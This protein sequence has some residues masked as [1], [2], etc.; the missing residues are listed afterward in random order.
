MEKQNKELEELQNKYENKNLDINFNSV[1]RFI[2]ILKILFIGTVTPIVLLSVLVI[3]IAFIII[4]MYWAPSGYNESIIQHLEGIY[5]DN[6]KIISQDLN[7]NGDGY[8]RI[9]IKN[10]E[11]IIFNGYH[12]GN[13]TNYEDSQAYK[14]K[15]YFEHL[16]NPELKE[17]F[18][19]KESYYK[20]KE[21]SNVDFLK[22]ELTTHVSSYAEFENRISKCY[23]MLQY[24]K[25]KEIYG[26]VIFLIYNDYW[27]GFGQSEENLDYNSLLAKAKNDYITYLKNRGANTS[28]IPFNDIQNYYRPETLQ[29]FINEKQVEAN[30]QVGYNQ[31]IQ[32]YEILYFQRVVNNI[33]TIEKL[34]YDKGNA[35]QIKYNDKVYNLHYNNN[36][37][38]SNNIPCTCRISYLEELFNA[39]VRYDYENK[40]IYIDI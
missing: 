8:Y 34:K 38:K 30:G 28:E 5:P 16:N 3:L 4:K 9:A 21:E 6:Y 25:E 26:Y 24:C 33:N 36:E 29:L 31:N 39:K 2:K 17:A 14:L 23:E 12:E 18:E 11:E 13:R 35:T 22:Y 32:E 1:E 19:P 37:L 7:E 27:G 10:N 15:Y 40:K 20:V